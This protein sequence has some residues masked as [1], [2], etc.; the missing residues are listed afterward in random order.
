MMM[1]D[2]PMLPPQGIDME[3]SVHGEVLCF[4]RFP[5]SMVTFWLTV[6]RLE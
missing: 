1:K 2:L 3:L 4:L 6:Y 5:G